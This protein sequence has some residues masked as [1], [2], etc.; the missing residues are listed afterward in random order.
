MLHWETRARNNS[1][2]RDDDD[3]DGTTGIAVLAASRARTSALVGSSVIPLARWSNFG[4]V[5]VDGGMGKRDRGAGG[6]SSV[7]GLRV[8]SGGVRKS[9]NGGGED[10]S[11]YQGIQCLK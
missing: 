10:R 4:G 9:S 5:G 7:G 11:A 6:G 8:A 3:D 1:D 2:A